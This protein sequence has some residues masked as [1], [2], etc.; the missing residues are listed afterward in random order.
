MSSEVLHFSDN[1]KKGTPNAKV[2]LGR[3]K[4]AERTHT[5]EMVRTKSANVFDARISW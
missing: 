2:A 3:F 4:T 1:I 5:K